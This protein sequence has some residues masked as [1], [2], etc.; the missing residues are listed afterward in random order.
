MGGSAR[1][2]TANQGLALPAL[3]SYYRPQSL[4]G[5]TAR[6]HVDARRAMAPAANPPGQSSPMANPGQVLTERTQANDWAKQLAEQRQMIED[7]RRQLERGA[8]Q[9]PAPTYSLAEMQ[10][11]I[12]GT[13]A[14]LAAQG[15]GI[16]P[17]RGAYAP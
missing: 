13:P 1:A 6:A 10:N 14:W 15:L 17:E 4:P 2:M 3:P 11:A 9:P 16:V 8:S 12:P 7:L 5:A